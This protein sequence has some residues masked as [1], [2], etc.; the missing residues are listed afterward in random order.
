[1]ADTAPP[2]PALTLP[3]RLLQRALPVVMLL[4]LL[5]GLGG[6]IHLTLGLGQ[7]VPGVTLTWRKEL[8]LLT[9]YW[10][11]PPHWPGLGNSK[12]KINDG[13]LCIDGYRPYP[14]AEVYGLDPRYADVQCPK[15][16]KRHLELFREQVDGAKVNFVID[17][18]GKIVTIADVPLVKFTPVMLAE[19]FLP[20]FLLGL[21][22]LAV[23]F[24]V[25]H[26][27]PHK[28]INL[29]FALFT[30]IIAV[31][32][33]KE[34]YAACSSG[35]IAS[36]RLATLFLATPWMPLLGVVFFHLVGL[37]TDQSVLL[38]LTRRVLRP[39][40]VLSFLFSLLG[41]F[42]FVAN[43]NPISIVL[44]WP[45]LWFIVASSVLA[46]VWGFVSLVWTWRKT[47]SRRVRR[48]AELILLGLTFLTGFLVLYVA[49]IF[50]NSA[51]RY[52]YNI[53]YLGLGMVGVIAYAILRYQLFASKSRILTIL[54]VMVGCILTANLV[55]LILGQ[56]TGFL[57]ILVSAL[58]TGLVLETR[59]GPTAFFNWLLRRGIVN[60]QTVARFSH[61]VGA[62]QQI[63]SLLQAAQDVLYQDLHIETVDVWLLNA[64]SQVLERF[65][66][67]KLGAIALPS[68]LAARLSAH[69]APIP[70]TM[71][72]AMGYH[73][74]LLGDKSNN[75]VLWV[76]LVDRGQA[77]GLMGLGPRWTGEVY[78][79]QDLE[80]IGIL[81]QQMA[82]SILNTRQW[83]HIQAMS[84][85]IVQA[86]EN[87]RRK[88]AR[89]LHDTILQFL[90]VLT[91]GLDDLRERQVEIADEIERW[92]DRIS[93]E[94]GQLRDLLSY[95][96]APEI[97]VQQGLSASLQAW[98]EHT[99]QD[100]DISIQA[101]LAPEAE[102]ALSVQAQ[103]TLYRVFREAI[104]NAV[105]HS[106]GSCVLAQLQLE[107]TSVRFSIRDDG[108]GFDVEQAWQASGR[109]YSSLQDMRIYVENVGGQLDFCSAPGGG[110]VIQGRAPVNVTE[111]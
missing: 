98:I 110:T 35:S 36:V 99:R 6:G 17:R 1:M 61:R 84:H 107:G 11:T 108:Q 82:L 83:E 41:V 71:P 69:P 30:N 19:A 12:L 33:M 64:E 4:I 55:H 77:V 58:V 39:Y 7:P 42:V 37:L 34:N 74:L 52:T 53:S 44:D 94:A 56:V 66:N 18:D 101:D 50:F 70:A 79:E 68:D 2:E 51:S 25:Y 14:D 8:R 40:Y 102:Q 90:L 62:L 54:L 46:L 93:A 81:A 49:F 20:S 48:Q 67:G 80:L 27:A 45:F 103:V 60:Y 13:I 100:T 106:Q 59:Q 26:A 31:F 72:L 95:L 32:A 9:V 85:L 10:T 28:E 65:H 78:D 97:L 15:G 38:S 24:A 75:I 87:E 22:M 104:R 21:G 23:G 88:I 16:G 111:T 73:T 29:V 86:E 109:G 96:R 5:V 76:P 57:P 3:L 92:Q 47:L 89:E 43:D 63:E 91:Y 105:K